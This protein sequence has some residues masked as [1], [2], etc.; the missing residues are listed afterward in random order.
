MTLTYGVLSLFF[1]SGAFVLTAVSCAFRA[2]R[3]HRSKKNLDALE[4]FFVYSRLARLFSKNHDFEALFFSTLLAKNIRRFGFAASVVVMAIS[5]TGGIFYIVAGLIVFLFFGD[6]L[7]RLWALHHYDAVIRFCGHL[8]S[9]FL[10]ICLP[11]SWIFF[12]VSRSLTS[13]SS[14]FFET[15]NGAPIKHV[16]EKILEI[17]EDAKDNADL[18]ADEKKLIT[19]IITF[20]DRITREVM[21]PRI[22]IFG[23]D[24]ITTIEEATKLLNEEGYSRIPIYRDTI[25]NIV[26]VLMYRD[27]LNYYIAHEGS[28][29][30]ASLEAPVDTIMKPALYA[31]ETKKVSSLL[32]EFRNKQVH[33]AVV[34]DEYGGTSGIV[35]IED[36]LEELVGEIA[37]EYD[38]DEKVLFAMQPDGDWIV[39]ASMTIL[40]I[41]EKLGLHIPQDGDYDTIGG[42]IF[43][44]SGTIPSP[45][46]VIHHDNFEIEVLKSSDRCVEQ[47]RITPPIVTNESV[48]E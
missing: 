17:L 38:D 45:G 2:I 40:E 16:K 10:F 15:A 24:A 4:K 18:D 37:D 32:K 28:K 13:G 22:K 47:V 26:G 44:R 34:V 35:T 11:L 41:E 3:L 9:M 33:F 20:K 6:L 25:D 27:I 30:K 14:L 36:I 1:L 42:Y 23:L 7:P 21:I 39:D 5:L 46:F 31:P 43:H 12:K 8:A 19:S 29:E 48:E